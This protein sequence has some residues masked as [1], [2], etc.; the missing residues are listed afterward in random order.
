MPSLDLE[1]LKQLIEDAGEDA[2]INYKLA[3][4]Y[5]YYYQEEFPGEEYLSEEEIGELYDALEEEISEKTI[6]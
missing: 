5:E 1:D 6:S 4:F 2:G 3:S